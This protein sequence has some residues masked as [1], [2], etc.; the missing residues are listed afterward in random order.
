[1]KAIVYPEYGP[2]QVLQLKELEKPK[3]RDGQVLI[4]VHAAS[5]NALDYR[6]FEKISTLGRFMAQVLRS[7]N[8]VLGADVAG[9]VQAVGAGV[10]QFQPGDEVFGV[11]S[12]SA[13]AFAEYTC[14]AENRLALKPSSVSFEVAAAVPVAA[15]TALQG[16][17][18]KGR[19]R[20]GQKVL[21]HGA[22]GGVGMFAVQIAKSFGAKVTAVCSQR[23]LEM[24]R[25]MGADHVVDYTRQD[26]S[27]NGEQYDLIFAVNGYHPLAVYQRALSPQGIYVCTGGTL[28]QIFEAMLLGPWKS[29]KGGKQMGFMGIA[30]IN[31]KDL[32]FIGELLKAGQIRP[33]IDRRYPLIETAKAI[34]YVLEEHAQGKV[35]ITVEPNS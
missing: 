22:S 2:P 32:I 23:N 34:Q 6:R 20:S 9:R 31:Q 27:K 33:F 14:A 7:T 29:R 11:S 16:L 8:K 19:I 13:G 12:G 26:F 4:Q 21:I 24:A 25:S 18:D 1:M 15:L 17:R 5:V 28:P 30:K 10:N 3:P 35:V